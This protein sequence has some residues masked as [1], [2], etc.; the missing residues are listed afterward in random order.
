[1]PA[2]EE[3]RYNGVFWHAR[4]NGWVVVTTFKKPGASPSC[5]TFYTTVRHIKNRRPA[6]FIL[7]NVTGMLQ[8]RSDSEER[9]PL[10]FCLDDQEHGLRNIPGYTVDWVSAS[11]TDGS[12]PTTRTRVFIFGARADTGKTS[13]NLT[14]AFKKFVVYAFK[15]FVVYAGFLIDP[16]SLAAASAASA[17]SVGIV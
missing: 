8:K 3:R 6:F 14:G 16:A 15:K 10:D 12:L 17:G 13:S 5:D 2:P 7:E 9:T 4:K 11:G 1:M